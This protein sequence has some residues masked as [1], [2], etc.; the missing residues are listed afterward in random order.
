MKNI[1]TY[2][3]ERLNISS[4]ISKHTY[5]PAD[6]KQ[7]RYLVNDIVEKHGKDADLND[8]DTSSVEDLDAMFL[9]I[10]NKIENIDISDW[11]TSNVKS[12]KGTFDGCKSFNCDLSKWN[13][14]NVEDMQ[15]MFNK[16]VMINSDLSQWNVGKVSSCYSMFGNC[17]S[18]D[19]NL[20][21]WDVSNV[22]DMKYMFFNCSSLNDITPLKYW[23]VSNGLDF[24]FMFYNCKN[25]NQDLS[26]WKIKQ[27]TRSKSY[28]MSYM[29]DGCDSLK[30]IPKWYNNR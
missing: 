11:D 14:S 23:N 19:S 3:S 26:Q 15:S 12:M 2:I 5:H 1:S 7:L 27:N 29:F 28:T 9:F 22:I 21:D 24:G 20:S 4:A 13:V 17:M 30:V 6:S 25:F 10:S 16:C 8:I 18:F